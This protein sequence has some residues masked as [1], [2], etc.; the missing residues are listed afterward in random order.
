VAIAGAE[1]GFGAHVCAANNAWN[2]FWG[3]T[4]AKSP[5]DSWDAGSQ[6]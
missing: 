4:C 6:P 3:G 1:T 5:F 2:W